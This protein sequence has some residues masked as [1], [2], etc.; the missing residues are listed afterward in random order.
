MHAEGLLLLSKPDGP[1]DD[2][3]LIPDAGQTPE[4]VAG[5]EKE[6]PWVGMFFDEGAGG[7]R[8]L[9]PTLV[10]RDDRFSVV[11]GVRATNQPHREFVYRPAFEVG[12]HV[13][14]Y[15]VQKILAAVDWFASSPDRKGRKIR[16]SGYGEGALLALYAGA[17][18][19]RID[20]VSITGYFG[21]VDP[22][23]RQPIY[24]NVQGLLREFGDAEIASLIA[25][26]T[27]MIEST[28]PPAVT[29][30]PKPHD[31]RSGAAPGVITP[32]A[33]LWRKE[34]QRLA[35]LT[36]REWKPALMDVGFD[37]GVR[38]PRW[39]EP[40]GDPIDVPA[41]QKRQIDEMQAFTQRLVRK[42][43][44]VRKALWAKA[45]RSSPAKWEET[46]KPLREKFYNDVIGRFDRPFVDVHA[47]SRKVFDE[48]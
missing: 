21:S 22:L 11:A 29:G 14:G 43:D 10:D 32:D 16:V 6:K 13:I 37:D 2:V 38:I 46:T 31:G 3:I 42:S 19:T 45:D 17:L 47:R 9:I 15:E 25:P 18:D 33:S 1:G 7:R 12:R 24:R 23:W 41:R 8:V 28:N 35:S 34:A 30:P 40:V 39:P 44:G 5:L 36:P 4:F 26:R 48:P 27:L 20:S